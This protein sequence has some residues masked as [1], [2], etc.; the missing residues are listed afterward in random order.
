METPENIVTANEAYDLILS[1]KAPAGLIVRDPDKS[2]LGTKLNFDNQPDL[3]LPQDLT[4]WGSLT[5]SN[6][7]SLQTLPSGLVVKHAIQLSRC[8]GLKALPPP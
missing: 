6:C 4:V 7:N 3:N 1:G 8:G 5:I 2:R